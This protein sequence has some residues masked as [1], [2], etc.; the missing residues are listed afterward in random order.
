MAKTV[1]YRVEVTCC[2]GRKLLTNPL[3]TLASD[4]A[5]IPDLFDSLLA[6]M[7]K[8]WAE[9]TR[10]GKLFDVRSLRDTDGLTAVNPAQ[11]ESLELMIVSVTPTDPGLA[12]NV[13]DELDY[14]RRLALRFGDTDEPP[15]KST[16]GPR[17]QD[18]QVADGIDRVVLDGLPATD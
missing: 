16:E 18:D 3:T 8:D 15:A 17:L 14:D 13:A 10:D 6:H 4:E 2:S 12:V 1:V 11:V 9:A 5:K 7:I